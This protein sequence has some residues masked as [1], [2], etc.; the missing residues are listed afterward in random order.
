MQKYNAR[1][2]MNSAPILQGGALVYQ[3]CVALLGE[4]HGELYVGGKRELQWQM[5]A[6]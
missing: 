6:I 5:D 4:R 2:H 3:A 1:L